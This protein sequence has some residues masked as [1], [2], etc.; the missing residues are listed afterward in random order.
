MED[1]LLSP[2]PL[3]DS[4]NLNSLLKEI[5]R[6][7]NQ[8]AT[9]VSQLE[10]NYGQSVV[11]QRFSEIETLK[12][13][14]RNLSLEMI[15]G[16]ENLTQKFDKF[17]S[18]TTIRIDGLCA[19]VE[20]LKQDVHI[21]KMESKRTTE[22]L[23]RHMPYLEDKIT[24]TEQKLGSLTDKINAVSEEYKTGLFDLKKLQ[25]THYNNITKLQKDMTEAN[26]TTSKEAKRIDIALAQLP[27]KLDTEDFN[28]KVS[29]L[30]QDIDSQLELIHNQS[31][32][33]LDV[34]KGT[35]KHINFRQSG[36]PCGGRF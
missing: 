4:S 7:L 12:N 36:Q 2:T 28:V 10:K 16:F 18:T 35:L 33:M 14:Y 8:N 1:P 23:Q 29:Q 30:V 24:K 26:Q 19:D 11:D 32:Q 25:D 13:S 34:I 31:V 9:Q 15:K 22:N 17:S 5:I 3:L 21:V 27:T 6:R 20:G